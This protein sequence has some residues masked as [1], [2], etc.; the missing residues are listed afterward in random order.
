MSAHSVQPVFLL[1]FLTLYEGPTLN[2]TINS[3]LATG[4]IICESAAFGP[5]AAMECTGGRD[6]SHTMKHLSEVRTSIKTALGVKLNPI[7]LFDELLRVKNTRSRLC[8]KLQ[9]HFGLPDRSD[10]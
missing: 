7:I 8:H 1:S 2:L 5:E 10:L 9:L 3:Y 6:E 4:Y